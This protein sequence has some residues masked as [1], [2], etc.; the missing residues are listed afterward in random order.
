[1]TMTVVKLRNGGLSIGGAFAEVAIHFMS[2][3]TESRHLQ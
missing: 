3:N 1:M 2:A